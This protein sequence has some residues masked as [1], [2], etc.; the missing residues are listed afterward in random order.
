MTVFVA[1]TGGTLTAQFFE[2]SGGGPLVDLDATPTITIFNLD[3]GA[4]VLGP[5]STGV[6]NPATGTYTY[7]WGAAVV[8]ARYM[9]VW[10]GVF[11]GD[12]VQASEIFTV[13]Y[14]ATGP[15]AGPCAPWS[16]IWCD[17]PE[18][19]L[20]ITG[21]ML[22]VAT[23]IL[24]AKSGR[25]FDECVTT[26]RPCRK[27]C[28]GGS[29]PFYDRWN[30][31]GRSWPYPYNYAG[32]WFNLGCGGCPGSC[33]CAVLYEAKL[34]Q[35]IAAVNEV[36]VDGE[37]LSPTAYRVYDNQML[38][39]TDGNSW[40][41]CNNLNLDTTEPNT[42]AVTVT[43]GT[44]VPESGR[45][46][47]GELTAELTKACVGEDCKL[48][49]PVQQLVRQGVSMTFLDPNSVFADGKIGLYFCDLFLSAFN[50]QGIAARAQAIDV[51]GA[52]ARRQTWP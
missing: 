48:P 42:W 17:V 29:W 38:I 26:L 41:V 19:G 37:V 25:Q 30:E 32:Q 5:T 47:V 3:S 11:D 18:S 51:D 23:E 8:A 21:S 9:A 34:P 22:S 52:F 44:R 49:S 50:P 36:I 1:N 13:T 43:L 40:P 39:R 4:N 14:Q 10:N 45:L 6:V 31:F 27:D 2:F 28:W 20:D 33:S 46:A 12:A 15:T 16:P 24:W 7:A 35:P